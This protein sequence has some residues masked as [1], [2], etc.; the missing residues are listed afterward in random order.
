MTIKKHKLGGS[1]TLYNGDCLTVLKKLPNDS[2]HCCIT[3]PPYYQLRDYGTG[4][5]DGGD[6][7]C[8]HTVGNQV[9]DSKNI[10]AIKSGI[11]PGVDA[12]VCKLCGANRV[13]Q[14]IGI[15][16]DFND[17]IANLVKVF[18][19]VKRVLRPD[20]QLWLNLGD[21]YSGSSKG[22]NVNG[23]F[24][25]NNS[26]KQHSNVGRASGVLNKT[27]SI[28][29]AKN[30]IGIPWR[31]ALA[32]QESGWI[33]RSDI[34]WQKVNNMP[35][36]VTDRPST[37]HE[38]LFLLVKKPRYYYDHEAVKVKSLTTDTD[39]VNLRTVWSIPNHGTT[40]EHYAAFPEKIVQNC[41]FAGT[42]E[43]GCCGVCGAPMV[44]VVSKTTLKRN[45]LPKD[46]EDYRPNVYAK[47]YTEDNSH[48]K[49]LAQARTYTKTTG[50][51]RSCTCEEFFLD[52]SIVLDPFNG[53]GTTGLV[54]IKHNRKYIGIELSEKFT[55]ITLR[56]LKPIASQP[57]LF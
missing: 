16:Q 54:T 22:R 44:R 43:Q 41:L 8:D 1:V 42:S 28:L 19:E 24:N 15:E 14:Q 7:D 53:S 26:H 5:W 20:G 32:L 4:T 49:G 40:E 13:D 9:P 36:A 35:S 3:S 33:L 52:Q 10:Q 51:E 38:Y 6:S 34:I 39:R 12:T 18:T 56:R 17:Y 27:P 46:H 25:E 29:P 31:V 30:L 23:T 2:I 55:E 21:S 50:W 11:R 37:T 57:R 48:S 47:K 45:Q